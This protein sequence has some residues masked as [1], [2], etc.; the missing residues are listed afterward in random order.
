MITTI[1]WVGAFVLFIIAALVVC[2]G[3]KNQPG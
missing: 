2:R 3:C 1:I